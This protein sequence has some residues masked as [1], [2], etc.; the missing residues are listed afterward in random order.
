[1]NSRIRSLLPNML[2]IIVCAFAV[3]FAYSAYLDSS[4][5]RY[6]HLDFVGIWSF[7]KF[8]LFDYVA[9]IYDNSILLNFQTELGVAP[10]ALFPYAY[11]PSFILMIFP[12]GVLS[13]G[14]AYVAWDVFTFSIYFLVSYYPCLSG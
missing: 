14:S 3:V 6:W 4:A 2:A 11:P 12:L 13:F 8:A 10:V 7:A 9:E 5:A 1:V